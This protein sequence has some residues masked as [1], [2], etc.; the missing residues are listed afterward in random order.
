[1][2]RKLKD[3]LSEADLK[4][5]ERKL[6]CIYDNYSKS[7]TT[8][9]PLFIDA[10]GFLQLQYVDEKYDRFIDSLVVK[11]AVEINYRIFDQVVID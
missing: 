2:V 5:E 7:I 9:I 10:K 4:L 1:M 6:M 8:D 3:H 11:A